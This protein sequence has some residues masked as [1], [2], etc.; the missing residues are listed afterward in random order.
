MCVRVRVTAR[1]PSPMLHDTLWRRNLS[2]RVM[3]QCD[4][5]KGLMSLSLSLSAISLSLSLS[6]SPSRSLSR[7][8]ARVLSP[9]SLYVSVHFCIR[10]MTQ[11]KSAVFDSLLSSA[12]VACVRMCVCVC[13]CVC[14]PSSSAR[15]SASWPPLRG[16]DYLWRQ[17]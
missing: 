5:M 4:M 3:C 10:S 14:V 12:D 7:S 15:A 17:T 6:L 11:L 13:V 16:G 2:R 1:L 9:T 8:R